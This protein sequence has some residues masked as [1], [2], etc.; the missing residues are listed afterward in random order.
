MEFKSLDALRW[1]TKPEKDFINNQ[2]KK[3]FIVL[4]FPELESETK[5]RASESYEEDSASDE[6]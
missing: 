6:E 5:P 3:P 1:Q 2:L 4:L